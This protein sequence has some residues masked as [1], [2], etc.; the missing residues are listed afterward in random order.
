MKA[1]TLTSEGEILA[2]TPLTATGRK[3]NIKVSVYGDQLVATWQDFRVE[4]DEK[5]YAQNLI[6]ETET[7]SVDDSNA[8]IDIMIYPNPVSTVAKVLTTKNI[9]NVQL[10]D[11]FGQILLSTKEKEISLK[12]LKSGV[13]IFKITLDNG[14]SKSIKII[15]K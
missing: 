3:N 11:S 1:V 13:Y 12:N 10:Y 5:I 7:F 9:I 2:E 4:G 6:V 8:L 15:K 14:A